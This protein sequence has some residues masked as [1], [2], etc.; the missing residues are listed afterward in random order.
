MNA[1]IMRQLFIFDVRFPFRRCLNMTRIE[2]CKMTVMIVSVHKEMHIE[3]YSERIVCALSK[4]LEFRGMSIL[5]S[6]SRCV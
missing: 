3:D 5:K 2:F 6:S 4:V 1:R